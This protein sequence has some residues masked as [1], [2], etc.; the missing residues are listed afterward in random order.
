MEVWI[1]R[2]KIWIDCI[3]LRL[4]ASPIDIFNFLVNLSYQTKLFTKKERKKKE[5]KIFVFIKEDVFSDKVI[6]FFEKILIPGNIRTEY[7]L[8]SERDAHNSY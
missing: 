6:F 3:Y 2:G 7:F 5:S 1:V 4:F 8:S